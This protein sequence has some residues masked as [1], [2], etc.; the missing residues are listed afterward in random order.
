MELSPIV[1]FGGTSQK[2]KHLMTRSQSIGTT[3]LTDQPLHLDDTGSSSLL[4]PGRDTGK[5]EGF[6]LDVI[7]FQFLSAKVGLC[8]SC[9]T[10][11]T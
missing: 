8:S 10:K 7:N 4:P 9:S 11:Y 3:G 2:C 6:L 5:F 1:D